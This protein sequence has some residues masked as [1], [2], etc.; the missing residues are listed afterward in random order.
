MAHLRSIIS[1]ILALLAVSTGQGIA[2][3]IEERPD[4]ASEI[5]MLEPMYRPSG[6]RDLPLTRS[7]VPR[8]AHDQDNAD[9]ETPEGMATWVVRLSGRIEKGDLAR[10]QSI[11]HSARAE[12]RWVFWVL[13]LDSPGGN[14]Q[15]GIAIGKWLREELS[16]QDSTFR[17][18]YVLDQSE[19]LS[20][21]ALIFALS[22]HRRLLDDSDNRNFIELGARLG[23][24][25]GVLP[26]AL[27]SQKIAIR[28]SMNL[29]YDIM[30]AY[31][32]L[33]EAQTNPPEL[34]L[35]ALQAREPDSF[36]EV[37]ASARAYD[38]GFIP[39][40]DSPLSEALS[41]HSLPMSAV[42]DMCSHLLRISQL[43]ETIVNEEYGVPHAADAE[44]AVELFG[45]GGD[46]VLRGNFISGESCLI[47]QSANGNLMIDV[48][49]QEIACASGDDPFA[50]WCAI[51]QQTT[52]E[53]RLDSYATNA[54]LADISACPM[55][56]LHP[57]IDPD[58]TATDEDWYAGSFGTAE[59]LQDL[60]LRDRPAADGAIQSAL[61]IGDRLRIS[62][63]AVT[64]DN[65]AIW[66]EVK[67]GTNKGWLPAR[68]VHVPGAM[69]MAIDDR[70]E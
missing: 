48:T 27:A 23:F 10:L 66:L 24:H 44:M 68:S 4:L 56:R 30:E 8:Q 69:W 15:E 6:I 22:S 63:C 62:D 20:A 50:H 7:E 46:Q 9:P 17:G 11:A 16:S 18:T 39:V 40:S 29:T 28:D 64:R 33:I 51:D 21:C 53:N 32:L 47:G 3:T 67:A 70:A 55:G 45:D 59:V 26:D 42:Y 1:V 34:I 35:E 41:L 14:F 43:P 37:E 25:M 61:A 19:C 2:A 49:S 65:Q 36:F 60:D 13:V 54:L 5:A 38:L 57:L 52:Y 31:M 12:G 58:G